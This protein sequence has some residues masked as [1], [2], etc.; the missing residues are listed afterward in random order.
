MRKLALGLLFLAGAAAHAGAKEIY[1]IE[2]TASAQQTVKWVDGTAVVD[3]A[4]D[5]A[6]VSFSSRSLELPGNP[7]TF[8]VVVFNTSDKPITFGPEN[9][10]IEVGGEATIA[11]LDPV[12]LD[13]KLRRDIKRRKAFATLGNALSAGSAN[14]ST[15]GT[16][17]Y[18]GTSTNGTHVMGTG[19]YSGTD[20]ALAQQ[21]QR[22]AQ[23]QAANVNGAIEARKDEGEESLNWLVRKTT[24]EPGKA[25]GGWVAYEV[26][27]SLQKLIRSKPIK[28]LV[29]VGPES[30]RFEGELAELP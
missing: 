15:S 27:R 9:V 10:K 11:M 13:T 21:Q 19:T 14:G 24:I 29:T 5:K 7:S 16:F 2:A 26:P 6:R 4:R 23:E 12:A 18:S 8:V 30:Y 17:S 20:P 28:V 22:A 25:H 1:A 3:E